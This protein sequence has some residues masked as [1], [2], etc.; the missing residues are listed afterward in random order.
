MRARV[1]HPTFRHF[2]DWGMNLESGGLHAENDVSKLWG[3]KL[4]EGK[5][6]GLTTSSKQQLRGSQVGHGH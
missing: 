3:K 5:A 2:Q 4:R 1:S 6:Q